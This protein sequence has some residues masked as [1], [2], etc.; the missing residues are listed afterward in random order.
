MSRPV[1]NIAAS[2]RQRLANLARSGGQPFENVLTRYALEGFLYRLG[3]SPYR[4]RFILKGAMLVSTW[5]KAPF[6]GTRD[7]DFL[8]FGDPSLEAM[9]QVFRKICSIAQNDG[10]VF[11][12]D[13]VTVEAN[14]E[15]AEYGGLRVKSLALLDTARI[16][17]VIDLGFG[18]VMEP[19]PQEI[20]YPVLLDHPAPR[21][22][23]Y[24]PETVI[25]EKFQAMV[26]LG[27][28][29]S[30]M[31]D[32]Y[33]IWMLA[34]TATVSS[35]RLARAIAATFARRNTAIPTE[36]PD[37]LT[38][39]FASDKTKQQQWAAFVRDN[40]EGG[41][42]I[43]LPLSGVIDTLARFIMPHARSAARAARKQ[44]PQQG[45]DR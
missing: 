18:D 7:L 29:N 15:D 14:R 45:A 11:P 44:G 5:I 17:I 35:D 42:G 24:A 2:I 12:L 32:I 13:A 25:A 6:R 9:R 30:R 23:A 22:R 4:D 36:T 10:L 43:D 3:I 16:R 28:A 38:P 1:I 33:D 27:R 41:Q 31:K 34:R 26:R 20:E 37:A 8:A 21:I 40:L 19:E 39:E